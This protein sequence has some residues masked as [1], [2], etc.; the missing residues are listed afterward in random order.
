MDS[1]LLLEIDRCSK[2]GTCR[3]VCP[4]FA[5]TNDEAMVAR[6]RL[7]LA[8]AFMKEELDYSA[9]YL[10]SLKSCIQCLRCVDACPSSLDV[11]DIV[12]AMREQAVEKLGLSPVTRFVF[13]RVLPNRRLYNSAIRLASIAQRILPRARHG[14]LRHLPLFF[15][16]QRAV[17]PI[18]RRS[19]LERARN[20]SEPVE[21]TEQ[22]VGF[23]VGCLINYVYP[24]VGEAL[25]RLLNRHGIDVVVPQDQVCCGAPVIAM[26]DRVAARTLAE[27]NVRA[28]RDAGV[29][30]VLMA[31]ATGGKTLSKDYPRILGEEGASFASSVKNAVEFIA[32]S[33]PFKTPTPSTTVTYHDPCH[34]RWGQGIYREPRDV[35]GRVGQYQEMPSADRCCGMGGTFSLFF[36]DISRRIANRKMDAIGAT[37]ADIVATACPGCMLQLNE[38]IQ[39]R[40]MHKCVKHLVEVV[41]EAMRE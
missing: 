32:E 41:E 13:R 18:A 9:R 28:F 36:H 29:D 8:E 5:E 33:V 37:D 19:F 20:L 10:R 38:G 25:M 11:G 14:Q 22:R 12:R 21:G 6:G 39:Q 34:L 7:T 15:K 30:T 17:P 16:G 1:H 31:C 27:R 35:L 4:V 26:G 24:E 40:G 2:C 3:S 23:F